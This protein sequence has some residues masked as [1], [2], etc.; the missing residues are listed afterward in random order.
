MSA[1]GK[2]LSHKCNGNTGSTEE[3]PATNCSLKVRIALSG[4]LRRWQWGGQLIFHVIG[5]EIFFQSCGCFVV[6]GLN[7]G[8][9][10]FGREFLMDAIIYFDPFRGGPGL[11]WD[12]FDI[13]AVKNITDHNGRVALAGPHREFSRQIRVKL[14]LADQD[15]IDKMGFCAEFVLVVVISSMSDVIGVFKVDLMFWRL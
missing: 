15:G 3:S 12:N 2:S 8:F 7:S 13:I 5:S 14:T 10:T 1:S 6:K 4:A 11:H 9:E